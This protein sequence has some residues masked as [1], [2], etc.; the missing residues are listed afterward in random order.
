MIQKLSFI[1]V[2]FGQLKNT[3]GK[4]S[5]QDDDDYKESEN[6]FTLEGEQSGSKPTEDYLQPVL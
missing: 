3:L 1:A 2:K 6:E 4:D 5:Y